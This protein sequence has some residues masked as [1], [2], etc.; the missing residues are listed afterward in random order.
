[1]GVLARV[2]AVLAA[3][4]AVSALP[5]DWARL[6]RAAT[7]LA[8]GLQQPQNAV[9]VLGERRLADDATD[10]SQTVMAPPAAE[11]PSADHAPLFPADDPAAP[12]IAVPKEDG[13][14]GKVYTRKLDTGDTR[15]HGV[16]V[17]NSSGK[18]V[19]IAAALAT[20]LT[21]KFT[22][23]DAP[24]VLITHTHTTECYLTHDDGVYYVDDETR[25][26]DNRKTVV[27]VGEA[28]ASQLR[29]AGIG[30]VHDTAI[31]DEP[32]NEAYGSSKASVQ[33]FLKQYP[34]IQVVLDIHRDAIYPDDTT[35][36]KPTAVVNG[37]KAAQVMVMVGMK[38]T[39]A[40]PNPYVKENLA[41]GA[42]LQQEMHRSYEGLARPMVLADGRYNQQLHTGSL[43]IEVGSDVN[44][45][46]EAVYAGEL[47]GK[48]LARVLTAK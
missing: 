7:L 14:G 9:Q 2:G 16:A 26:H 22:D 11:L 18:T 5:L 6:G 38:N 17:R 42:V 19:D 33:K 1:M 36:I 32:Y 40:V 3:V 20:K 44:T 46:A 27:A 23:T 15:T 29:M 34:S 47:L 35:R 12:T 4:A 10:P 48:S 13:S 37:R 45:A 43:L 30:V 21:P 24:Q 41:L 25:S 39:T 8:A 31:H 28:V